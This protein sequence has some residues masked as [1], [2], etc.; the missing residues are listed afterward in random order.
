MCRKKEYLKLNHG[1]YKSE[2]KAIKTIKGWNK[3]LEPSFEY[4]VTTFVCLETLALIYVLCRSSLSEISWTF[5]VPKD[6]GKYRR[7]KS[8]VC[9]FVSLPEDGKLGR[10]FE[11][12]APKFNA[13]QWKIL[14][15]T[16]WSK[17][18][19]LVVLYQL[20]KRNTQIG[21]YL[22]T[23]QTSHGRYIVWRNTPKKFGSAI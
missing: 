6:H 13:K 10:I 8:G 22:W 16:V 11:M 20:Y 9:C 17:Y 14:Q 7:K 4:Q 1:L 19:V 12:T 18:V 2:K 5:K 21:R 23:V 15:I 3:W